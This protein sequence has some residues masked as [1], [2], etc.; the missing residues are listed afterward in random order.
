MQKTCLS[1]H[2]IALLNIR[3][4]LKPKGISM[5]KWCCYRSY[6]TSTE[7]L[8]MKMS[9]NMEAG[10]FHKVVEY[11]FAQKVARLRVNRYLNYPQVKTLL[12]Q[13]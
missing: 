3:D 7:R 13:L 12:L 11:R 1:K 5:Y 10:M 9:W 6:Q 2:T 4:V 8:V